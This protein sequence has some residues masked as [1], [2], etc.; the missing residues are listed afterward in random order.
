MS[1]T[2]ILTLTPI[3]SPA[4]RQAGIIGEVF[5]TILNLFLDVMNVKDLTKVKGYIKNSI[6][7]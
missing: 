3:F 5:S 6:I 2:L 7:S 1:K 4:Y